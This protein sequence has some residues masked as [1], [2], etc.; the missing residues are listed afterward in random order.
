MLYPGSSVTPVEALDEREKEHQRKD[1]TGEDQAV[2]VLAFLRMRRL[3]GR[4]Q[5]A[6]YPI[7][8]VMTPSPGRTR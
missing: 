6:S 4:N 2:R 8:T 1:P 3:S 7:M 5:A